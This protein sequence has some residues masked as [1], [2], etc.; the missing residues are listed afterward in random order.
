MQHSEAQAAQ[1][2]RP[3]QARKAGRAA[4]S[5]EGKTKAKKPK[6]AKNQN[7]QDGGCHGSVGSTT[8]KGWIPIVL[9]A[10]SR[11]QR[12]S[13]NLVR[14]RGSSLSFVLFLDHV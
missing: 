8:G 11:R 9:Q 7:T 13:Q 10:R 1:S 2:S 6:E 14:L 3:W 5:W 12:L 4:C